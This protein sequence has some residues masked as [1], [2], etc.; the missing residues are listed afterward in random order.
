MTTRESVSSPVITQP[1]LEGVVKPRVASE[2]ALDALH[3]RPTKTVWG[4]E[5][6]KPGYNRLPA[7]SQTYQIGYDKDQSFVYIEPQLGN[8]IGPDSLQVDRLSND[9]NVITV[10]NGEI[11]WRFGQKQVER[12]QVDVTLLNQGLGLQDGEYQIGYLLVYGQPSTETDLVPGYSKITVENSFLADPAIAFA[13]SSEIAGHDKGLAITDPL[14]KG[15]WWPN[16]TATAGQYFPGSWYV[17]DFLAPVVADTFLV[18]SDPDKLGT[19]PAALYYSDD[20]II[21]QKLD[22][23][24]P[25]EGNWTFEPNTETPHRYWKFFF[26]DGDVTIENFIYSGEGYFPDNRVLSNTT[27]ATPYIDDLYQEIEGDYLLLAA[28]TVQ[29]GTVS[30]IRDQRR[31]INRKYEPV[32][33]WLT[34]FQ[35][36]SIRCLFDD[37]VQYAEINLAPPTADFHF[38]SEMADTLCHGLGEISLGDE[39]Q[40]PS[41]VFPDVV[42]LGGTLPDSGNL[43]SPKNVDLLLDP[44]GPSD[45]ATKV[46]SDFTLYDSWSLDNGLYDQSHIRRCSNH[47]YP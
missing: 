43:I 35:D 26:W 44:I 33:E 37:V 15:A 41:I 12:F 27:I 40:P 3:L 4:W 32:A 30:S 5:F 24:K 46:Y 34:T 25:I 1:T 23:V 7:L 18:R 42:E 21:W 2:E 22:E 13:V 14:I 11:T 19:S 6:G 36:D 47:R 39:I 16:D 17:L 8:L 20:A 29:G 28:F 10:E 45:L 38:Y 31:T 9:Y